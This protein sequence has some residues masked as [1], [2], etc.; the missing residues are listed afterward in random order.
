MLVVCSRQVKMKENGN[1]QPRMIKDVAG[2]PPEPF[3]GVDFGIFHHA[4]RRRVSSLLRVLMAT[5]AGETRF[6][7]GKCRPLQCIRSD[8]K[9]PGRCHCMRL[10]RGRFYWA[11]TFAD[12]RR[13]FACRYGIRLRRASRLGGAWRSRSGLGSPLD[14]TCV[15]E[16]H[17]W[18]GRSPC[19]EF[20]IY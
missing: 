7:W 1:E 4:Q 5:S 9:C 20:T 2:F 17:R 12:H 14:S 19:V 3:V 6:D 11:C 13:G 18:A 10:G 15:G 8:C 16:R